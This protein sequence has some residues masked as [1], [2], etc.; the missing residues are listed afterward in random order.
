M[1]NEINQDN[2][3]FWIS[4]ELIQFCIANSLQKQYPGKYYSII[5]S[6][7]GAKK[8]FQTQEFVKFEKIWDMYDSISKPSSNLDIKYLESLE[9]KYSIRSWDLAYSERLFYPKFN[10]NYRYSSNEILSIIE[11]LSKFIEKVLDDVKPNFLIMG[12]ITR[13]PM[14]IIYQIAKSKG[15]HVMTLELAKFGSR[16]TISNEIDKI[17]HPE[18]YVKIEDY[19]FDSLEPLRDYFLKK[20][21][22]VGNEFKPKHKI[23]K[24]KKIKMT[25][26]FLKDP[27]NED[28]VKFY[29][30]QGT[31]KMKI[32]LNKEKK[33]LSSKIKKREKFFKE[34]CITN[35]KNNK[36]VY[37][38][39]HAEP[40][41]ELLIQS[42]F[43]TNQLLL[44]YNIARS[45]PVNYK[46]F[47]K[48]HP[49]MRDLSGWRSI[50]F[51]QEILDLPNVEIIHHSIKPAQIYENCSLVVTLLGVAGLESSFYGIPSVVLEKTDYSVLPWIYPLKNMDDL[52]ST[53]DTAL[54]SKVDPV[55][56]AKYLK[57]IEKNS[58][59]FDRIN[60]WKEFSDEFP[61]DGFLQQVPIPIQKFSKFLDH[62]SSTFDLLASRYAEKIKLINMNS[63]NSEKN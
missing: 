32:L 9:K 14:N 25:L 53:I 16:F 34:F 26:D 37:Y 61:Y 2:I 28:Y 13:L 41:R 40:E 54:Q 5:E 38:P 59:I 39:L 43:K 27:I 21:P 22:T 17:D 47:V 44:I 56:L 7:S 55:H 23:S 24:I 19:E 4:E 57:F 33:I 11:K 48:E 62:H 1:N 36:F 15:I 46:L 20:K 50:N 29:S 63:N 18:N 8:F 6:H 49:V 31:S 12:I 52:P 35:L 45:L 51:Y 3:L 60:Y 30:H 58:I 42:P 10:K